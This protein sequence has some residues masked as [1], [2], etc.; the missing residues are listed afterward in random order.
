[1]A[2]TVT[3]RITRSKTA[4]KASLGIHVDI[5]NVHEANFYG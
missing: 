1:M 2:N 5:F 3:T 4:K